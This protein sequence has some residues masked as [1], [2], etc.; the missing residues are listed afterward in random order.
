MM[1]SVDVVA[2]GQCVETDSYCTEDKGGGGAS[3]ISI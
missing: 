1:A 2:A 3:N